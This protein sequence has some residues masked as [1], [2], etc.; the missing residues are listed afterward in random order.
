MS[1]AVGPFL[2]SPR[3]IPIFPSFLASHLFSGPN[4][5]HQLFLSRVSASS[6]ILLIVLFSQYLRN[7]TF[8]LPVYRWGKGLTLFRIQIFKMFPVRSSQVLRKRARPEPGKVGA[9]A[10][11]F[12][13]EAR[14]QPGLWG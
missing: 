5:A 6:S 8:L 1:K 14:S 7:L 12:S 11:G 9:R 13:P 3:L 10:G 4:M 2:P